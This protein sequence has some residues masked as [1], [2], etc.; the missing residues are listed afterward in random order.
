MYQLFLFDDNFNNYTN[1]NLYY[2]NSQRN[3]NHILTKTV[4]IGIGTYNGKNSEE[5]SQ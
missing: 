4:S 5:H 3:K 2:G 1:H